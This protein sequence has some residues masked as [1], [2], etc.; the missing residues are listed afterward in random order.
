VKQTKTFKSANQTLTL[1]SAEGKR[2]W[3]VRASLKTGGGKGSPKAI[4]GCRQIVK[5]EP[6]AKKVIERLAAD[7]IAR[8]W[9]EV[10]KTTRNAFS[11]V[12]PPASPAAKAKPAK[13]MDR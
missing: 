7:A 2:G 13:S 10:V 5:T 8:G 3:N 1:T 11:E 4:T 9:V 6:E 12:P